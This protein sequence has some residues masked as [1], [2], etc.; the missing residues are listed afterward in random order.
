[1]LVSALIVLLSKNNKNNQFRWKIKKNK[2]K[3]KF[4]NNRI[5]KKNKNKNQI[6]NKINIKWRSYYKHI[7]ILRKSKNKRY[8]KFKN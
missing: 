6:N 4:Y 2:F 1:M 8:K 3:H 5:N 7:R